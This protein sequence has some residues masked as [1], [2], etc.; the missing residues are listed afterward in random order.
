MLISVLSYAIVPTLC[1]LNFTNAEFC[2]ILAFRDCQYK[3]KEK[4]PKHKGIDEMVCVLFL[5][6]KQACKKNHRSVISHLTNERHFFSFLYDK[7]VVLT[8]VMR[9]ERI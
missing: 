2:A 7:L 4:T 8:A 1:V 5:A 9:Q 6:T 3:T